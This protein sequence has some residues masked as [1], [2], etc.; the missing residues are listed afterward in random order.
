MTAW[1]LWTKPRRGV[2]FML[3]VE[4]LAVALS[5]WIIA[6]QPVT[7]RDLINFAAITIIGVVATETSRQ[8]E[9]MRRRLA[10]TPHVNLTSVWTLSAALLTSPSLAVATVVLLYGHMWFRMWRRITGRHPY[11]V[12]FSA[13]MVVL[14][15]L[16]AR[17]VADLAP[18]GDIL[19][20][21]TAV[22][23][24]WL[25][26][27]ILVYSLV[28]SGL[29]ALAMILNRDD[30][31]IVQLLGTWQENSIEYAT[32][33]IGAL[34]AVLLAWRP[35][36][37]ALIFM[38]LYVL[39]RSVLIRQ[40]EHAA[41][42]DQKTGLLNATS[43]Q[44]L[45]TNELQRA[46]SNGTECAVLMV[47]LDHFKRV[48]DQHGHLAG[49]DVL[50]AVAD[51]MREEVRDYDLCGRFGGEEFVVLMPEIELTA[52][53]ETAARICARVRD[54]RIENTTTGQ[55]LEGLRLS[56]SIGVATYPDA[57]KELDEILLAADNAMFAAKDSGRDQVRA[58]AVSRA[59]ERRSPSPA[60]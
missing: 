42:T 50:R 26:L 44:T 37:V 51:A 35:W 7:Q 21:I 24:A 49:D 22:G 13:S 34:T 36:L 23:L 2:A 27:V 60:E 33:C 46:H 9:R 32:L 55:P 16:A 38:P 45:A 25:V 11:R 39:H 19:D 48:N 8:V 58:V 57:G 30:T 43:W 29:V 54:L 18:T 12:V 10:G 47:D 17:G 40:L 20:D 6:A 3:A 59:P 52:A 31:S 14:S 1:M 41:T 56:A 28:N 5:A 4:V 53:I 15:C